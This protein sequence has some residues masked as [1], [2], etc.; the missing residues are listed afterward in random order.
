VLC[1]TSSCATTRSNAFFRLFVLQE[2]T[3]D[4]TKSAES[5]TSLAAKVATST[6]R[7]MEAVV[8]KYDENVRSERERR[9][10][11]TWDFCSY[12][13]LQVRAVSAVAVLP[14]SVPFSC[15]ENF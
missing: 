4:T 3:K 15:D 2:A 13:L 12:F 14:R 10:S 11:K 5:W 9:N 8:A 7:C 1:L 6:V